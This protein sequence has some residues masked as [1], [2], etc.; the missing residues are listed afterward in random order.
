MSRCGIILFA[1]GARDPEWARP[2]ERI[3][4]VLERRAPTTPIE[5]AF[6][7]SMHPTLEEAMGALGDRGAERVTVVPLFMAQG[8]HLRKD[9]PEIVRRAC[10][11]NPGIAVR[12][13]PAIGDVDRLL[14]AIADWV[15]QEDAATRKAALDPPVA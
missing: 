11:S 6:L 4:A 5:L 3:R 12:A 7:E 9:F 14:E 15:L 8:N 1:H 2:F 10:E 13:A